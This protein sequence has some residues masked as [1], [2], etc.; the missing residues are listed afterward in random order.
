[1]GGLLTVEIGTVFW[2]SLA[3]II[4]L[5]I[6]RKAAWGPILK[7][8]R[9]REVTIEESLRQAEKARQEMT[10]LKSDNEKMIKEARQERE[11]VMQEARDM[12]D[13]IIAESKAKAKAEGDRLVESAREAIKNE[14]ASAMNELKNQV[15]SLSIDIAEKVVRGHLANDENQKQ[16]VDSLVK[17]ADLN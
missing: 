2:A 8:L 3:F 10:N 17:D 11:R 14:K 16:L 5:L 13:S 7:G 6:L 15:A 12:G 9:E 4:V 1:M